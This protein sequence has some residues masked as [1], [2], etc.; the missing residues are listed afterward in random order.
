MPVSDEVVEE[1]SADIV[2]AGHSGVEVAQHPA[3]VT[4]RGIAV[5]G[6]QDMPSMTAKALRAPSSTWRGAHSTKRAPRACQSRLLTCSVMT[7]PV[8]I[9][10]LRGICDPQPFRVLVIGQA[11][12]N[13]VVTFQ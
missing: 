8:V 5:R 2:A 11:T 7:K 6:R 4:R 1:G 3:C 12:R 10:P 13:P 9:P